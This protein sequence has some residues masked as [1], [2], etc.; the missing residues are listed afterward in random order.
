M[1][2]QPREAHKACRLCQVPTVVVDARR[3]E[4][5]QLF[6]DLQRLRGY[7]TLCRQAAERAADIEVVAPSVCGKALI[8]ALKGDVVDQNRRVDRYHLNAAYGRHPETG[9]L[10]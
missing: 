2:R 4:R 1:V 3:L 7:A 9:V 10:V 8:V 6:A 5:D